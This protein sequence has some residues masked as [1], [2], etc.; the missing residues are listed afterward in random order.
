MMKRK[1]KLNQTK[2]NQTKKKK[3]KTMQQHL[4][5]RKERKILQNMHIKNNEANEKLF[6]KWSAAFTVVCN[7]NQILVSLFAI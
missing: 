7:Q 5:K 2:P 4:Q 3:Q 6:H 1:T